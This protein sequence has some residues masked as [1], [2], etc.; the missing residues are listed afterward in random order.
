MY[1]PLDVCITC[2][3]IIILLALF[4]VNGKLM[5]IEKLL[6]PGRWIDNCDSYICSECGFV[7]DNPDLNEFGALVCP[8][9]KTRHC[10]HKFRR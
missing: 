6:T 1:D 4:D 10:M 7:T 3:L 2:L 9:C 8:H 5:K